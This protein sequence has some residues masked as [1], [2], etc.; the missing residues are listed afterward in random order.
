LTGDSEAT[1]ENSDETAEEDGVIEQTP[2]LPH[3]GVYKQ[4]LVMDQLAGGVHNTNDTSDIKVITNPTCFARDIE[5]GRD[6]RSYK[7]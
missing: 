1:E 2:V 5:L 6:D 7:H 3:Q 4:S